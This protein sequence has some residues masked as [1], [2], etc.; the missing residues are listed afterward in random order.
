MFNM[1][2][3]LLRN[4]FVRTAGLLTLVWVFPTRMSKAS[5]IRLIWTRPYTDGAINGYPIYEKKGDDQWRLVNYVLD[6]LC[7]QSSSNCFTDLTGREPGFVYYYKVRAKNSLGELSVDSNVRSLVLSN[8]N[9]GSVTPQL[10]TPT[11]LITQSYT[12]TL[13]HIPESRQTYTPTPTHIPESRPTYTPTPTHIPESICYGD[14]NFNGRVEINELV[15][16][17]N[18]VL[19]NES[20]E[21]C[22]LADKNQDERITIDELLVSINNSLNGCR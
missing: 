12:P 15:N 18:I 13:T 6:S 4:K 10:L 22:L 5:D 8:I 7:I 21:I 19:G 14:C 9:S 3:R 2:E 17:V 1:L 11:R 20:V 16:S